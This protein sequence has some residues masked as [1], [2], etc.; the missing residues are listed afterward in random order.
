[1]GIL[2][3]AYANNEMPLEMRSWAVY[4]LFVGEQFRY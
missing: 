1:M 2:L 3:L 4:F